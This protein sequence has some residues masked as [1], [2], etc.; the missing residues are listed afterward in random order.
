M[1]LGSIA[2]YAVS[3]DVPFVRVIFCDADAYDAGYLSPEDIAGRVEVKGRGG[4]I[5]QPAVF[6][7]AV[8]F[9]LLSPLLQMKL[10]LPHWQR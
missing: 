9:Q 8:R 6:T 4:T 5:L 10:P 2:S 7:L 3:K 1:A